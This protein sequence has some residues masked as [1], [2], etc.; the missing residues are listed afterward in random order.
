MMGPHEESELQ[1]SP[2]IA[3]W[4]NQ[5]IFLFYIYTM[6]EGLHV[7]LFLIGHQFCQTLLPSHRE[8]LL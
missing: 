4:M 7:C 1:A 3:I 2:P 8:L 5:Y 6:C